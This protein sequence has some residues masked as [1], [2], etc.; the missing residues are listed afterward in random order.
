MNFGPRE[1]TYPQPV[2]IVGSYDGQ[3]RPDAMVCAWGGISSS[4]EICLSLSASHKTTKNILERGAFTVSMATLDMMKSCDFVG[5]ISANYEVNADKLERAGFT[6]E[7]AQFVDAPVILE[8][9]MCLE[10]HLI[11]YDE[12]NC[13]L[14][15][16]IENISIDKCILTD[17]RPD[18]AKLKPITFDPVT[19]SYYVL[20]EK[21][22][23]AGSEVHVESFRR[24]PYELLV[25]VR[26]FE[27]S[28][29][30]VLPCLRRDRR[31]IR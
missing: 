29:D 30:F 31:K 14:F 9:P 25:E 3:G 4:H 24:A 8:L 11:S 16:E 28:D 6:T 7:K 17:H 22:G 1:W 21:V 23:V 20:G 26:T 5:M 12:K 2:F 15:G 19:S 27:V 18:P 10:C 13:H